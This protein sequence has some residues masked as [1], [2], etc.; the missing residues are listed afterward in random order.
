MVGLEWWWQWG[1]AGKGRVG[2]IVGATVE[3]G[4]AGKGGVEAMVVVKGAGKDGVGAMVEV[5]WCG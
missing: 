2:A 4:G 1:S 3:V 5:G